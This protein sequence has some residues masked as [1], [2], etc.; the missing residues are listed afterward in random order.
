MKGRPRLISGINVS[1]SPLYAVWCMMKQRCY[2]TKSKWFKHYGQ[3]GIK[4]CEEWKT[5]FMCFYNWAI[6]NG[7]VKGLSIERVENDGDYCPSNCTWIPLRD[8]SK[9]RRKGKTVNNFKN[10]NE[11]RKLN[12]TA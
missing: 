12:K 8:Q 11:Q 10:I 6:N 2:N 3:R 1:D 7:Y 9:N 5:D 4:M